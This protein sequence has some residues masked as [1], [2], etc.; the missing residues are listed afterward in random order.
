MFSNYFKSALNQIFTQ[1]VL[2][3]TK[4]FSLMLGIS[5]GMLVIMH[6]QYAQSY[7]KHIPNW[8]N[9]Y[10]I[11][12]ST[13]LPSGVR[14]ESISTADPHVPFI[15]QDYPQ[16]EQLARMRN[17]RNVLFS[18]EN[19]SL[20]ND[21]YWVEPEIITL[22]SL[23][24]IEG[25][26]ATALSNP[27]TVVLS[28]STASKY[29]G[30]IDPMGEILR[31]DNRAELIVTGVIRDLP[32]NTHLDIEIMVSKQTGE[33]IYGPQFM[34]ETQWFN[35]TGNLAYLALSEGADVEYIKN[36]LLQFHQ[37]HAPEQ[38]RGTLEEYK[39]TV[40]LQPLA[41][42]HLSPW[43]VRTLSGRTAD[44][45]NGLMLFALVIVLTS[46]SNFANLSIAQIHQRA[47]EIGIRKT[48]GAM[49][50]Q[51]ISQ[52][53]IE[54]M[55]LTFIALLGSLFLLELFIPVYTNLTNTAFTFASIFR[56]DRAIWL[57]MFVITTGLI[58]GLAPAWVISRYQ[59]TQIIT[60]ISSTSK[61]GRLLRTIITV[62]QFSIAS[63]LL[64]IAVGVTSQINH[65]RESEP[66]FKREN[67]L[68]LTNLVN[69][70]FIPANYDDTAL[71][72]ELLQSPDVIA[73]S[74]SRDV[75]PG[76]GDR[77]PW[78][79]PGWGTDE[80]VLISSPIVDENFIGV[81][82]LRLIAGRDFS[83]DF[84]TD[85]S[86]TWER[87]DP[88]RI[89]AAVIT[90]SA[91]N[92]FGFASAIEALD[93]IVQ[94]GSGANYRV[95]G[96]V[97]DFKLAGGLESSARSVGI[98]RASKDPLGVLSVRVDQNRT[99]A[100]LAHIDAVWEKHRP[101]SSI[102]RSF[103]A[104]TF[105]NMVFEQ[106]SEIGAASVFSALITVFIAAMGLYSL[107]YYSTQLKSKEVGIRK[108]LGASSNSLIAMLTWD[109]IKPILGSCLLSWPIAYLFLNW[110]YSS[111]SSQVAFGAKF[112]MGIT[113]GIL[114]LSILIT[115][116]HAYA[117]ATSNPADKVRYE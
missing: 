13:T 45:L 71:V 86:P 16:I 84:P 66:G 108:I 53:I 2:A 3:I 60:E 80:N 79:R 115:L 34:N 111:Y 40:T 70:R 110:Y 114:V 59:P 90:E 98:L 83:I 109:F 47:K 29:F 104:R 54:S 37:R 10:R 116:I 6:V 49:R 20:R 82:E 106:T 5:C 72:E 100:A 30:D 76:T 9:I 67:L 97:N 68:V 17:Q 112:Y 94:R 91:A 95:I 57:L 18:Y 21:M 77:N 33:Q 8:Q 22:F 42:I 62:F 88:D 58:S 89:Y 38:I 81:Y 44:I 25:D 92:S 113:S 52:L 4:I 85:F 69:Y 46:C 24:F 101:N 56:Y 1:P 74:R 23:E 12:S 27:N 31:F 50:E 64:I 105:D 26:S 41:D 87:E 102:D 19:E 28:E 7:D 51:I 35:N 96:V 36:D 14:S 103:L 75:P 15:L 61:I 48:V 78:S 39:A 99:D 32:V 93:E 107:V 73:V 55:L 11:V 65:L 117:V 43:G 63:V